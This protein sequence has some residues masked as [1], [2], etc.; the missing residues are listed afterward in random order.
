MAGM[1]NYLEAALGNAVLRNTS[2]TSPA[3]VY[4]SLHSAD[5]GETGASEL[6]GNN[7]SRVEVA[8]GA[9]T[10]GVFTNSANVDSPVASGA[11]SAATHF[12]IWDASSG[13]NF[14]TGAALTTPRTIGAGGFLRV[15]AG[16]LS[17]TFA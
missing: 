1:S 2:Y 14:L 8:F 6:T 7:Y 4:L 3:K 17:V 12:G 16:E 13:G 5:P 9:P 11:W 15:Q 10:D